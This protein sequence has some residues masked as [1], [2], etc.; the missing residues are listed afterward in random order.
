M[1]I[2]GVGLLTQNTKES[3]V[4]GDLIEP[5]VENLRQPETVSETYFAE[6]APD[7]TVLRVIV[8]DQAF[9]DSGAVGDPVNWEQTFPGKDYLSKEDKI[10]KVSKKKIKKPEITVIFESQIATSTL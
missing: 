3:I 7:G 2:I 1:V 6:I 10:D 5:I 9:I 4:G 8:A